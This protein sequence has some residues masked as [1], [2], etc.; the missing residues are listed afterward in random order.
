MNL[1]LGN[2]ISAVLLGL[3]PAHDQVFVTKEQY[4]AGFCK[5][6]DVPQELVKYMDGP[7]LNLFCD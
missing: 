5:S 1:F 4:I 3:P 7:L 2:T 6:R